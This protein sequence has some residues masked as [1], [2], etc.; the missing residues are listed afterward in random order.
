MII[1]CR[2]KILLDLAWLTVANFCQEVLNPQALIRCL[3]KS[4]AYKIINGYTKVGNK[5]HR[6]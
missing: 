2:Y 5:P 4:K 3:I 6:G 1:Y